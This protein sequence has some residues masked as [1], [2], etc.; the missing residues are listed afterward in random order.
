MIVVG[1]DPH[2]QTHTAVAVDGGTGQVLA[3]ITVKARTPGF[4]RA[5]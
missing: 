5:G 1:I 3:E 4:E 2:K